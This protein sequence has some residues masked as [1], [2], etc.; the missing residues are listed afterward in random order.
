MSYVLI[1]QAGKKL[2]IG[3]KTAW[4]FFGA[5]KDTKKIMCLPV[6]NEIDA[7]SETVSNVYEITQVFK[8]K[9]IAGT[10]VIRM[11]GIGDLIMVA[12]GIRQ[13]DGPV[14]MATL[15]E[16]VPF[17]KSM[18]VGRV[19]SIEDLGRYN[20]DKV[21]DLRFAVEPKKLGATCKGTWADYTLD[22]RSD[23]FDKL[24]GV[25][26]GKKDFH[27]PVKKSAVSKMKKIADQDFIAINASI[28]AAARSI[29][30]KYIGPLCKL[31]NKQR[32][33][34][35]VLFGISQ[36]WNQE[37]KEIKR[38]GVTN[39]IDQTNLDEMIALCS[40]ASL[41]ITPDTGSLHVAAALGK[42]TLALFGNINP[43]TR[44]SYYPTVKSLYPQGELPCIPCWDLHPCSV[45]PKQGVRCMRLLHPTRIIE[46]VREML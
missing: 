41:V 1:N 16:N 20:F 32:G 33:F 14:T 23:A 38:P 12:S 13:M 46:A 27:V 28:G 39:M 29:H 9:K 7:S 31:I 36:P 2:K 6:S 25:Y 21:I 24:L 5:T 40:L 3:E 19:I 15:P 44:V 18:N 17:M 43:R 35:V 26:P 42:P 8:K 10:C 30:P 34:P 37:L 11:G 4:G 45:E 22:D